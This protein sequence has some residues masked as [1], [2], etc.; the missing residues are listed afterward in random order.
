M[1][2]GEKLK[3]LREDYGY[4]QNELSKL[5]DVPQR[6][7]SNYEARNE[8]TG[9][10]DYIFRLCKI[11]NM[12]VAEFFMEDMSAVSK[13]LPSYI[14]PQNAAML[15]ILNTQVDI[16]TRI[17]VEEAFV[18]ILEAIVIQ[19]GDRLKHMKEYVE[20]FGDKGEGKN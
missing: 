6:S 17:K 8:I 18:S 5:L 7:I 4:N 10:L 19:Y 15:K 13:E 20:L 11:T 12:P 14:T 1:D 9:V 2:V 16:K 3:K